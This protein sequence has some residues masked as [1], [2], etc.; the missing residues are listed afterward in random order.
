MLLIQPGRPPLCAPT[1][2]PSLWPRMLTFAFLKKKC[3]GCP[4]LSATSSTQEVPGNLCVTKP[5]A[6]GFPDKPHL[7]CRLARS[8]PAVYFSCVSLQ[9]LSTVAPTGK[10]SELLPDGRGADTK[11][12]RPRL[13]RT[14]VGPAGG[15]LPSQAGVRL[16]SRAGL[17][18]ACLQAAQTEPACQHVIWLFVYRTLCHLL[19]FP[20]ASSSTCSDDTSG[21]LILTPSN[22][23]APGQPAYSTE[24]SG[25]QGSL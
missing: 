23:C 7:P 13:C 21:Y 11:Q 8:H 17:A 2:S 24:T 19:Q 6:L 14:P 9:L 4:G 20:R 18:G 25:E 15:T 16:P 5:G 3:W 12:N 22:P 10:D 1:G